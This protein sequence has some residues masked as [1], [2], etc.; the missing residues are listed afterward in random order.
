MQNHNASPHRH[1]AFPQHSAAGKR[2]GIVGNVLL[3]KRLQQKDFA[4]IKL[5]RSLPFRGIERGTLFFGKVTLVQKIGWILAILFAACWF[6]SELQLPREIQSAP[7]QE[8]LVW[9]RTAEGWEKVN[10]W[11]FA[12]EKSPPALHPGIFSLLIVTLSLTA[13]IVKYNPA[14]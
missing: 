10:D 14:E 9:R 2:Y 7:V 3:C 1:E 13:A 6:A 12:L 11:T 4:R 8:N 5:A